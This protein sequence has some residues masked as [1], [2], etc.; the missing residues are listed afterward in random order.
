MKNNFL[1]SAQ[2]CS[3]YTQFF[4]GYVVGWRKFN[5]DTP[6]REIAETFIDENDLYEVTDWKTLQVNF[7]NFTKRIRHI[8]RD[9]NSNK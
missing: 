1:E 8:V 6:I 3:I 9:S 7:T 5:P 4:Y 2:R